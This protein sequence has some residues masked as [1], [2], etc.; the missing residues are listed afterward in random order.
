VANS[1]TMAEEAAERAQLSSI[2]T[3]IQRLRMRTDF[4][5]KYRLQE[6]NGLPKYAELRETLRAAISDG[7]WKEGDQIPAEVE[8][9]RL[10]PFSL[11]TV[12]K[13]LKALE[14]EGV[15][16]RRQGHGT[17][18]RHSRPKFSDPWHFRFRSSD[19]R[20]TLPAY[21]EVL[22]RKQVAVSSRWAKLLN[23]KTG[24]L[25]QI[26]R[27]I[28]IGDEFLIY[29]KFFVSADRYGGFLGRPSKKLHS[30]D[31][32]TILHR[33]Y[34]VSLAQ[35]SYTMQMMTF[36]ET[37]SRALKLPKRT[38]GMLLEILASSE[39]KDPVYFQQ[40]Y[41]PLSKFKLYITDPSTINHP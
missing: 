3:P 32:K 19:E 12:Q 5:R 6:L 11:G 17:F 38:T 23:P 30:A 41:I 7:F 10:T 15:L 14:A 29:N 22:S 16:W 37:V 4:Y 24:R 21:P 20:G 9:T 34:N 25:I 28:N 27:R 33:E 31:F 35:M 13:A 39:R 2:Y 8:I 36:P 1:D 26:D 40:V 18:V